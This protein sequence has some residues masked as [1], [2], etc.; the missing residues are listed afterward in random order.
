MTPIFIFFM[1]RRELNTLFD[2]IPKPSIGRITPG[3]NAFYKLR[4]DLV[5]GEFVSPENF[6]LPE[7]WRVF[8]LRL[9]VLKGIFKDS[10]FLQRY[11]PVLISRPGDATA[12]FTYARVEYIDFLRRKK[13]QILKP[14]MPDSL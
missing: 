5:E 13:Y 14:K 2:L 12:F 7:N 11:Q 1:R 3:G 6:V 8:Q 4:P 10:I 9:M